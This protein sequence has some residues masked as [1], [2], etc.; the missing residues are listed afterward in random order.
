MTDMELLSLDLRSPLAYSG[1][2]NPPL[3]G[4]PFGGRTHVPSGSGSL[5]EV[6]LGEDMP[7]GEEEI[8]LFDEEELIVFD[9]DD[10]PVLRRPF[11]RPRY[12]GR[13]GALV[14][15]SA[16]SGRPGSGAML[17]P[18]PYAF[19]QWRPRDQSGL[20]SGIEWF[21]Q[22]LWWERRVVKG[23]YILRRVREDGGLA[24]QAL[25]RIG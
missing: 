9:P 15:A 7:E 2:E 6:G 11:P 22:E 14:Q 13:R 21:A 3:S 17:A 4:A 23:P 5:L 18:G 25:R 20:L 16:D 19:V 12:Y 8:F 1:L 10:G 24:T